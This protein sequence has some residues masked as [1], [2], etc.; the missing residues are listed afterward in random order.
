MIAQNHRQ[1]LRSFWNFQR[2]DF[3]DLYIGEVHE[4][5]GFHLISG[6][7]NHSDDHNHADD[8]AQ[9]LTIG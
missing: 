8:R 7:H 1:H 4:K 3:L 9:S 6:D 2:Q 5:E